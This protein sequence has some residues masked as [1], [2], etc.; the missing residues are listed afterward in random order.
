V[1]VAGQDVADEEDVANEEG[2]ADE[3]DVADEEAQLEWP[4]ALSE[5]T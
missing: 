1:A 5:R 3:E 2:V 4:V